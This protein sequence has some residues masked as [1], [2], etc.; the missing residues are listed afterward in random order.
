MK[1]YYF[2]KEDLVSLGNYLL[3]EARTEAKMQHPD[4]SQEQK[5]ESIKQ[6]SH[7]DISNWFDT[8]VVELG[9]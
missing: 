8:Q 6:V 4:F 7:A 1:I 5:E 3:S 9:E 2:S